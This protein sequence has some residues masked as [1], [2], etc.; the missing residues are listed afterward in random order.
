MLELRSS[1]LKVTLDALGA[2]IA[3]CEVDGVE[4]AFGFSG[5]GQH[6]AGD[7]YAGAVIGRHA[8]RITNA[9]FP[10]DGGIVRL[11][12]NMGPHQ[13]HGGANSFHNQRWDYLRDGSRITFHLMSGDGEEG[14]PGVFDVKAIYVLAGD[15]LSLT[16]EAHTT[17]PTLCNLTNHAYWN[18]AGGGSVLDHELQI[19]GHKFFPLNDVLLPLGRIEDVE[20]TGWDF[21]KLRPIGKDHDGAIMLDGPRGTLQRGLT[22]RDPASGRQL[23]VWTTEC[24]MQ[25]YTAIHWTPEMMGHSGPLARSAALAIEPQNVADA[26]N[27][28]DFP[29]SILRPG[30]TYRNHM[31]WRFS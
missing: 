9:S 10:L 17:K 2:R 6:A 13:I 16:L 11:R 25:T 23:D 31:E 14:Y 18:L 12:P 7:I 27:H 15:T 24:A 28:A 30:E 3:S 8:G 20:G 29:S 19:P 1:R 5:S 26:P 22:L 21:R 4:T